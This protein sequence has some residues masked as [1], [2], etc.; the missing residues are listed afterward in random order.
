[1]IR[2]TGVEFDELTAA[3]EKFE[4]QFRVGTRRVMLRVAD[5]ISGVTVAAGPPDEPEPPVEPPP[6][7]SIDSLALIATVWV[8][9][10]QDE[11][12][13]S[14][15]DIYARG[16]T[17]IADSI[18]AALEAAGQDPPEFVDVLSLTVAQDYL[19]QASNRMVRF[20]DVLWD[21]ARA[22]LL[23]GLIEGESIPEL[24]ERLIHI[25]EITEARATLVART[26]IIGASNRGS[27]GL[28]EVAGFTGK[29]TWLATEDERTRETHGPPPLGADG[30]TVPIDAP[31]IVGGFP[32]F[33][34]GDPAGPAAEVCNCRCTLTYDLDDEPLGVNVT[35]TT[36]AGGIVAAEWIGV[37]VVEGTP[38]GDRRMF[39]PNSID[40]PDL[41]INLLWQPQTGD[42]H[43]GAVIV[44]NIT[45]IAR[46]GNLIIGRGTF[47]LGGAYGAEAYRMVRDGFLY[48]TSI[49]ADNFVAA[50]IELIYEQAE[51]ADDMPEIAMTVFHGGRLRGATLVAIPAFV[52]ARI[53][54]LPEAAEPAP[55][56]MMLAATIGETPA[57]TTPGVET[58]AAVEP[59]TAASYTITIPDVPPAHWFDEPVDVEIAGALT[60]TDEGRIYGRLA[61]A[62][63]GHRSFEKRVT[64]PMGNVD[65]S[66]FMGREA[67]TAG[68]G[69]VVCGVVTMDCGHASGHTRDPGIALDHYDNTCSIVAQVRV[70]ENKAGVWVAGALV[71]GVTAAQVVKMMG[72]QLSG[73][74]RPHRERPGWR[75]LAGAL[76]VPVPGF[77]EART[78][79]SVR[80]EDGQLVASAIPVEYAAGHDHNPDCGC[81]GEAVAGPASLAAAADW[82]ATSLQ[83]DRRSRASALAGSIIDTTG[84]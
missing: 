8:S 2:V 4:T 15:A 20:A 48:G 36:A 3:I 18:T 22:Q 60:V 5:Q 74:W 19:A 32:L 63:V 44:G 50:D 72:S 67:L 13:P 17:A 52:E 81:T 53:G 14:L 57:T 59:L 55:I 58:V 38:T 77:P 39:A 79:A 12:A 24:A 21:A 11:L 37:L 26:E 61:P 78:A 70:G 71:P 27:L 42:G 65:Y 49:D 31:F 23:E 29:K 43:D 46:S 9:I 30:Q 33:H 54:L 7:V 45:A 51:S 62:N 66:L 28:V 83:L 10:V 82:I 25:D 64:V 76:L 80:L 1:M 84:A 56:A 47:D 16:A 40:W 68:G 75:E 69:R 35:T 73:D 6:P 41:P 34:P